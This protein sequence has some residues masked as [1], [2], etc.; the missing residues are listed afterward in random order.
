MRL[1]FTDGMT[2]DT[3]GEMRI[4]SRS[5]GLYVVGGGMLCPVN[6][7][8]DGEKLIAKMKAIKEKYGK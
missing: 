3:G 7:R 1:G 4:E 6:S 8:E 5:D 2:F